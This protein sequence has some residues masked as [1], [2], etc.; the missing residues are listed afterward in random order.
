MVAARPGPW[1]LKARAPSENEKTA[2][3]LLETSVSY[4]AVVPTWL[5]LGRN[6]SSPAA[7]K[8]SSPANPS[9]PTQR[10]WRAA[11]SSLSLPS[12]IKSASLLAQPSSPA[13]SPTA[14][15]GG[16]HAA[17][18][19]VIR[20]SCPAPIVLPEADTWSGMKAAD[21]AP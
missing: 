7:S 3:L 13:R 15:G 11:R 14:K 9:Q 1:T 8:V 4:D 18:G 2:S 6:V 20:T 19:C 21:S 10:P 16:S 17:T 12:V 5:G